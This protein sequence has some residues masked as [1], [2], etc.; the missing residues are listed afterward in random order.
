[1]LSLEVGKPLR[2]LLVS[3]QES[4]REEVG[5]ALAGL[6]GDVRLDWITQPD[7][8]QVRAAD[9]APH[10]I[11]VDDM[12]A[13]V[14]PAALIGQLAA[15]QPQSALLILVQPAA[16]ETARRAVLLGARGFITKPIVA[17][18]LL[19][20][21]S[22]V[23]AR[24]EVPARISDTGPALG[25]VVVFC[26]PK[27]GTGRTTLAINTSISL[28]QTV[29]AAV[30]L[31]DADYAAPALDV[32]LSL[33]GQRDITDLLPKMTHLDAELV[34]GVLAPHSSGLQVL[35]APPPAILDKPLSLPQ[36]QQLLDRLKRMF[37][38]VMVD[39]GLP[40]DETAFAFLDGADVI[41][42]SVMPEMV[43]M[44]NTRLMLDQFLGRGYPR[45]RI[46]LILNRAD[47]PSGIPLADLEAWLGTRV[48][49]QIPNDQELATATINRGVPMAVSHR[50]SPVARACQGLARTL[51]AEL[52]PQAA[53]GSATGL[54]AR[55]TPPITHRRSPSRLRRVA[56]VLALGTCSVG[57][58]ALAGLLIPAAMAN[59]PAT[60]IQAIARESTA[61]AAAGATADQTLT[62]EP[63]PTPSPDATQ[64]VRE[65]MEPVPAAGSEALPTSRMAVVELT[66]GAESAPTATGTSTAPPTAAVTETPLPIST[67]TS[68]ASPSP[69][70]TP[71]PAPT[72]TPVA[73]AT[74]VLTPTRRAP[75]PTAAET[76]PQPP[77]PSVT[78]TL[79]NAPTLLEPPPKESRS[80]TVTFSWQPAGSLPPGTAY[81][82][83]WWN[84]GEDPANARGIAATTTA[85]SLSADLVV[86]PNS[87]QLT[88]TDIYWT[89]IIVQT[90]P[91]V[92]LTQPGKSV[93]QLLVYRPPSSGGAAPVPPK[94]K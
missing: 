13:D 73:T 4:I 84:S 5:Q 15:S 93:P 7:L 81:E 1:V 28:R 34:A 72:A 58:V 54:P 45:D 48:K 11:I 59:R 36:V 44:R 64:P 10:V 57:I 75:V 49:Y 67:P 19:A 9:L 37:P 16:L 32:A 20:A 82:V 88:G 65:Q 70:P 91:Y 25:R 92:R 77:R 63:L 27:G 78:P 62:S 68:T 12:L 89:V 41:C 53:P 35:L 50:R 56:L 3:T 80:G 43:G 90:Q 18:E 55:V 33:T 6:R 40:L 23:Y 86:L 76:T 74:P 17:A 52:R 47:L 39:L 46:W 87:G 79:P 83:V 31:V 22:Q 8:A 66:Q 60:S 61:A 69:E 94:P 30:V 29:G 14:D 21:I 26:A 71:T 24:R 38:W 2:I 42:M 85:T 51:A